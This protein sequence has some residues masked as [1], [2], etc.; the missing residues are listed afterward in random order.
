MITFIP[1]TYQ[2]YYDY[3]SVH[4]EG[5][6]MII[7]IHAYPRMD[8]SLKEYLPKYIDFGTFPINSLD[9]K[10]IVL[11]NTIPVT[12]EYELVPVKPND[13]IILGKIN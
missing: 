2:Y 13:A 5:E 3:I 8:M 11:N 7:P 6:K 4:C 12:F 1:Q 10:E 9:T